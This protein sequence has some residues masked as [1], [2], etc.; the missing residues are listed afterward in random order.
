[1]HRMLWWNIKKFEVVSRL[2]R[3]RKRN[4][5]KRIGINWNW[6]SLNEFI[7][8]WLIIERAI[9]SRGWRKKTW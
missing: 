1:M 8:W 7:N 4:L 9:G 6:T 5:Q 3:A 2:I